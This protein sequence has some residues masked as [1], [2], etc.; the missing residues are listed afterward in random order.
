MLRDREKVLRGLKKED[1]SILS[2]Y[3]L[4][5]NFIGPHMSLEDKTPAKVCGIEI[6]GK[7]NG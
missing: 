6:N 2:G 1:R 5:Y 3:H 4:F 7:D